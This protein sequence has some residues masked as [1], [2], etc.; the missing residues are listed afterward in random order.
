MRKKSS[1]NPLSSEGQVLETAEPV[2]TQASHSEDGGHIKW[3]G[4][5]ALIPVLF[6]LLVSINTLW[7]GFA[8]D[9]SQQVLNN[10]FIKTFRNLPNAFTS[11]VWAFTSN[12]I[13]FTVDPYYRPLFSSLFTINYAMF[14]AH[15]WG[16]HLIN[17]L[18]HAAV[19]FMVFLVIKEVTDRRWLAA[20]TAILFAVHPVH[21]ESVAW[22]SGV[23]DPLLAL[24][25]LPAFYFYVRYRKQGRSYMLAIAPVF[26]FLALLSKEAAIALPV[27]I[28]FCELFYFNKSLSLKERAI[29]LSI[30]VALFAVP[31]LIYFAMRYHAISAFLFSGNPRYPLIFGIATVPLAMVKY[32]ALLLFPVNYSYQHYTPLVET[33]A[34]LRLLAPLVLLTVLVV[35]IALTRSRVLLFAAVW[36]VVM[37]LPVLAT[38][39]Q[40]EPGYLVQ[41]RY[42]YI[43]SI[44]ICLAIALGIEWLATR[45]WFGAP[46]YKVALSAAL[47][48]VVVFSA[49]HIK[50]NRVWEDSITVYKHCV[51]VAPQSSVAH[52]IL[53]RT[54]YD[55]GRPREAEAAAHTA[56][57]LD[58]T[59]TGAYMNLSYFSRAS[60]RLDKAIDYLEQAVSATN[61]GP[62]TRNDLAT[63]YLNLGL[64]YWEQ[65]A[66]D[67]AESN[68]L[69]SIEILPRPVAWYH[70]G[71]FYFDRRRFEEA[72]NMF[73]QVAARV[74]RWFSPIHIKLG[75][76]YESLNQIDRAL[77]EYQKFLE[78]APPG[79]QDI[80]SV[81][82]H[83]RQLNST[84]RTP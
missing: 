18:I 78:V 29:R 65:K 69:K 66:F 37:L 14:G 40:F 36:F 31:T 68:L 77:A 23:S 71:Q 17:V 39:Q 76:T 63:A 10:E 38:L 33:I 9:D 70:V 56:L 21:A 16:W 53:S 50:Q 20:V 54:Y 44:G 7:N 47:L 82:N 49:V 67:R 57:D 58:S 26:Y 52:T 80:K 1:S 73:E 61:L 43:P 15:A 19:T 79:S 22:V 72:L 83:M 4:I 8:S 55:A 84:P 81:Q 59:N 60:G 74:P 30:L 62:M 2:P 5:Y 13:I 3:R 24:L 64:L 34:S 25:L 48:L 11:S 6:A 12:D 32:L 45:N 35:G 51:A 41:E 28:A 42:L 75:Q 46:G 27:F